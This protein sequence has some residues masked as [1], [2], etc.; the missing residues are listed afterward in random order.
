MS[1]HQTW[2]KSSQ[3]QPE[4]ACVELSVGTRLTGIR[5]TKNRDGGTLTVGAA[6]FS[7][8]LASIKAGELG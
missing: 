4:D 2:R 5:D 1:T 3:S 8:F 6:P 7:S